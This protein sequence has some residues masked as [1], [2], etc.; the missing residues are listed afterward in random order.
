MHR[1]LSL[2]AVV[3]AALAFVFVPLDGA[4]VQSTPGVDRT[5]TPSYERENVGEGSVT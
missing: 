4:S 1:W 2:A 3:N 5:S